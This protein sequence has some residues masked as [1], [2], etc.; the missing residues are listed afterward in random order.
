MA[1]MTWVMTLFINSGLNKMKSLGLVSEEID[2]IPRVQGEPAWEALSQQE[3]KTSARK[4]EIYAAMI[5][6]VDH[7][8]GELID[9][10]KSVNQFDNTFIFFMSD[11]GPE[12]HH[13][14]K[15]WPAVADWIVECC[16]NSYENMGKLNS[17]IWYGPNWGRVSAAP[18]RFYKGFTSE[19][20]IRVPAFVSYQNK[21]QSN[22]VFQEIVTV[23]D[24]MPTI[25]ELAGVAHPNHYNGNRILPIQGQSMLPVL[26][27][28]Q[29][30]LHG[31]DFILGTESFGKKA[32]RKG[33]WKILS[34]PPP[35]GT[36]EWQLF[37]LRADPSEMHNLSLQHPKKLKEL[38]QLWQEYATV[39]NV[40][41]QNVES[42]Y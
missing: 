5:D 19:G 38:K 2:G 27:K 6:D 40:I 21:L 20:G 23:K 34:L 4:M 13:L 41:L 8:I 17:Y 30:N 10:L 7:Y 26:K 42:L 9:Y 31:E 25:L 29:N 12:G 24:V 3:K 39:N 16:D 14:D 1:S 36:G 37:N 33:D 35:H 22:V 18:F 11:N 15:G 32:I 28:M